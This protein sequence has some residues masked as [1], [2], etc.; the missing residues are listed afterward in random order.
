LEKGYASETKTF[1]QALLNERDRGIRRKD[2]KVAE[3][4]QD[5]DVPDNVPSIVS[6]ETSEVNAVAIDNIKKNNPVEIIDWIFE[7]LGNKEITEEEAPSIGAYN[8]LKTLQKSDDLKMEFYHDIWPKRIPSKSKFDEM[9]DKMGDDGR[10][11][12]DVLNRIR[13]VLNV[14][15]KKI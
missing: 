1:V 8:W 2:K 15:E 5:T 3:K 6:R 9:I 13:K 11:Q 10:N 7:H 12:F 14:E 4:F